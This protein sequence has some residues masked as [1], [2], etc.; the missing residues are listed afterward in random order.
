MSRRLDD[1]RAVFD[2]YRAQKAEQPPSLFDQILAVAENAGEV[3]RAEALRALEHLALTR[4]TLTVEDL[5]PLVGPTYDRRALGSVL[6]EGARRGWIQ[7]G[8][9]VTG[10]QDRHGR[11]VRQWH[12]WL[13]GR[14]GDDAA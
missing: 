7:R 6:L 11:A 2:A 10:N 12:S 14:G 5:S 1:A 13:Y 9:W 8:G 3:W 4:A